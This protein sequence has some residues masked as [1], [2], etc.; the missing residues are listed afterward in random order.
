M[1]DYS[2]LPAEARE[3]AEVLKLEPLEH[4]GG[5]FRQQYASPESTAIYYLLAQPDFSALHRLNETEVYHWYAGSALDILV[6]HPDGRGE[7]LRLGPNLQA[8]E[9]PQL[10]VPAGTMHGSSPVGSWCLVGTTMAPPFSWEGFSLGER[11]VLQQQFP[12]FAKEIA[13]LTRPAA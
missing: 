7:T 5:L 1:T 3:I 11:E 12:D 2:F 8:G 13:S 10:V 4:E 6:L 9:R